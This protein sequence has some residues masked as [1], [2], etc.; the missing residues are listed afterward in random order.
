MKLPLIT[1]IGSTGT[2]GQE[3]VRLLSEAGV[4]VR[5]VLRNFHRARPLPGIAWLQ[6]D[7]SDPSLR[8][9]TLAGTDRLFLLTGNQPGFGQTQIDVIKTAEDLGVKH[10]VKLSAL[11]ATPRTKS[12][13]AHEHWIAEQALEKSGMDWTILRPHVF[14]QNWL[15]EVAETVR[16]DGTI[17]AAI[18]EGKVPFIDARD[19][20][21]VAAEALLHPDPHTGKRYVLTGGKAAGYD[22]LAEALSQAVGNPVTYRSLSMDEM[23]ARMEKQGLST[24]MIDSYL[25][26]AAYQKAGGATAR[27]S[28]D[29]RKILAREPR[30]VADFARD[31]RENF[32]P[33]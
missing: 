4:P 24:A 29:V 23:R 26:L 21:A 33:G 30:T 25:A 31:Y 1:L 9:A 12:P 16:S 27:V 22:E 13:L 7:I 5:A 10:V 15:G 6:A 2:I 11:G 14:M 20:A 3:L 28:E 32:R 17:Y 8:E 19:I 18:G